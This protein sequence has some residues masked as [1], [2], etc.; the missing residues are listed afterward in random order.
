MKEII[1]K[2]EVH[3][4]VEKETNKMWI[5]CKGHGI[6]CPCNKNYV[7]LDKTKYT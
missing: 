7:E 2:C 1:C 3:I 5:P 6:K 4:K